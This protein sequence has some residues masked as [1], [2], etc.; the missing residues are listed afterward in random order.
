MSPLRKEDGMLDR[1]YYRVWRPGIS[2]QYCMDW[3]YAGDFHDLCHQYAGLE[4]RLRTMLDRIGSYEESRYVEGKAVYA[5]LREGRYELDYNLSR[6]LKANGYCGTE[7]Q[8]RWSDYVKL[9]PLMRLSEYKVYLPS[10]S[11]RG[12]PL[13]PFENWKSGPSVWYSGKY[14]LFFPDKKTC[15]DAR[16]DKAIDLLAGLYIVLFAQFGE[17]LSEALRPR[18]KKVGEGYFTACSI[19]HTEPPQFEPEEQ[20]DFDWSELKKKKDRF[21]SFFSDAKKTQ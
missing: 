21:R 8:Y 6:S 13:I 20:Y 3:K 5:L 2:A 18:S 16:L 19:F 11:G 14:P 15:A 10:C 7:R 1:P 9:E 12:T 4:N 17:N